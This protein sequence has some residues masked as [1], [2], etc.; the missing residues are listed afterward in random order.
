VH[1]ATE[2]AEGVTGSTL[3]DSPVSSAALNPA[4]APASAAAPTDSVAPTDLPP[5]A[6]RTTYVPPPGNDG[7]TGAPLPRWIA[8]VW[9]AIALTGPSLANFGES[10]GQAIVRLATGASAG[11][12]AEGGVAGV[13]ASGGRP[14]AAG[15][16]PVFSS[17]PSDVGHA[18]SSVPTPVFI[19][20]GLL[21]LAVIAVALAVR[22]EIAVGRRQ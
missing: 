12:G 6:S 5:S 17:I 22:R 2:E 8:Y 20:L 13:H 7:S 14:E 19:Y 1:A 3:P 11:N 4:A 9:P 21:V 15:P 10:L 18:F 16:S